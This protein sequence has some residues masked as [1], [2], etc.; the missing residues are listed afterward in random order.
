[1]KSSRKRK[2]SVGASLLASRIRHLRAPAQ[3]RP[4][5][6]RLSDAYRD[7]LRRFRA[8]L[9]A[10]AKPSERERRLAREALRFLGGE[11]D[12]PTLSLKDYDHHRYGPFLGISDE[13]GAAVAIRVAA[14]ASMKTRALGRKTFPLT[15]GVGLDA[16]RPGGVGEVP[17]GPD[18]FAQI[19]IECVG[20]LLRTT[21]V[22]SRA[23]IRLYRRAPCVTVGGGDPKGALEKAKAD[24]AAAFSPFLKA[25]GGPRPLTVSVEFDFD[26]RQS[27]P[28]QR[29]ILQALLEYV[30]TSGIA[31]PEIQTIALK[32]RIG[33][34]AKGRD[35]SIRAIN[36][37]RAA[38]IK[39]VVIDGVVRKDADSVVSLPGLLN[40]LM[41]EMVT[42]ILDYAR[43][44]NVEVRPAN[45]ADPDTVAREIWS[46]L[47]TARAMGLDLGKYGLFPLGL[48]ECDRIVAQVQK[49]FSDWSAAPVFYVDQGLLSQGHIYVGKEL[50]KG[51][52][53]CLKMLGKHKVPL[54]LIDTVDKSQ[55]WKIL[56]TGDDPKGLLEERQIARLSALGEQ[57][58]VR[59]LWAG[60]ITLDQAYRF[61]KLGVFGIYV[62][63]SASVEAPVTGE[64]KDD[65]GLP[66]A[67][68]PT[69]MGVL[70]VKTALEAGY[71]VNRL[72]DGAVRDNLQRA[73]LDLG[74]LSRT[75]PAAWR[76]WWKKGRKSGRYNIE[77]KSQ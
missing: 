60:G 53:I 77:E 66:A 33:W 67:T 63:T 28:N 27:L 73:G 24:L 23:N 65:P 46:A 62:T 44:K 36:L 3:P 75:L 55:G 72:P 34:G 43:K 45:Q 18:E 35:A 40:Y 14:Y 39:L 12:R 50:E 15:V 21:N 30:R 6:R 11:A 8:D 22:G 56:K 38:G 68:R 52:E 61:G 69:F 7:V 74:K 26:H 32:V 51:V 9:I 47:N 19:W 20:R 64:Y 71:L 58:G 54:C 10:G 70:N 25:P 2:T 59:T 48:E 41:P 4:E 31:S 37:A 57:L 5:D 29:L 16:E 17:V 42:P 1:M 76:R 13:G 49:W